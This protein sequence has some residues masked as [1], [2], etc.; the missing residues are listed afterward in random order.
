MSAD[1]PPPG[2]PP[3]LTKEQHDRIMNSPIHRQIKHYAYGCT[4]AGV[5]GGLANIICLVLAAVW[6]KNILQTDR[7]F[8]FHYVMASTASLLWGLVYTGVFFWHLKHMAWP[9]QLQID[10]GW[11]M[12][13]GSFAVGFLVYI[14][15]KMRT[16]GVLDVFSV[17]CISGCTSKLNFVRVSPLAL[18]GI[19]IVLGGVQLILSIL[20]YKNPIINPPLDEHGMPKLQDPTTGK[21]LPLDGNG[22]P[23][24]PAWLKPRAPAAPPATSKPVQ[25]S[26]PPSKPSKAAQA[27]KYAPVG[28]GDHSD[29]SFSDEEKMLPSAGAPAVPAMTELGRSSGG[30][31]SRSSRKSRW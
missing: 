14:F 17:S 20:L 23:I 3:P 1:A 19:T 4:I 8:I 7:W 11:M 25:K 2:A 13:S 6:A 5:V 30:G 29:D 10:I 24:I 12:F 9:D 16:Y 26:A 28:Q 18:A 27:H 31:R 21:P 15:V 22:Q